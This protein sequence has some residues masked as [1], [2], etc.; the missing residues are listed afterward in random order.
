[1]DISVSQNNE[2]VILNLSGKIMGG[3]DGTLMNDKLHE[4]LDEEKKF[5]VID[6]K[7]VSLMNSSGLGMLIGGLTTM[8]NNGGNLKLACVTN[9]IES[10]MTITKLNK[11]FESYETVDEAVKSF[12]FS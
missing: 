1:M 7:E 8:R 6:L 5:V 9:K 11:L 10:L 2:V 12:D 4:L 3:P